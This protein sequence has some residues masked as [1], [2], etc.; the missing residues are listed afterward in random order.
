MEGKGK[1]RGFPLEGII[2]GIEIQMKTKM[3]NCSSL[4]EVTNMSPKLNYSSSEC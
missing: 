4:S 1:R 2:K 3:I